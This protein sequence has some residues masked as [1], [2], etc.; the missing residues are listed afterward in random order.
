MSTQETG[1][2]HRR[3]I[4]T[5]MLAKMVVDI[6]SQIFNP[7]LS[8]LSA[9]LGI[10]V[11]QL[12][13]LVGLRNAMGVFA[14]LSGALSDRLGYKVVLRVALLLAAAGSLLLAVS[15][16]PWMVV[17]SIILGGLGTSAFVPNLQA[18]VSAR[19]PY[20]MRARGLG[21]VEYSWALT[22]IFGLSLVGLLIAAAG[23]RAPFFVLAAGM[24][25]MSFVFG[26]MPGGHKRSSEGDGVGQ[27]R[28]RW[29]VWLASIFI[30]KTNR[31]ST[32]ATIIAG[33][34]S[35]F[36]AMQITIAHGV[37]LVSR[38]ELDAAALGLVA[39]LIGCFD[40]ASSV[41]VSLFTDRIGKKR[42]VLIGIVGSLLAYCM[43][44][45]LDVAVVPAVLSFALVRMFFEFNIVSHFTLLS[46][47]APAQRGQV[48]TLGA[49]ITTLGY[50]LAGFTGPWLYVNVGLRALAWSSA[51]TIG[52]ALIVVITLVKEEPH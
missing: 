11:V 42:S 41:A 49:A 3:L 39:L 37:W 8:I 27:V 1:L 14:P 9:G 10:G 30:V 50:T 38:Y 22:G 29:F 31:R 18:F 20:S 19:L 5:G 2:S 15:T 28:V 48:M 21:I 43:M 17:L 51:A 35:F 7:F 23:W 45:F 24:F 47:Q 33:T 25:A 32:Y 40:L 52:L 36:A 13:R 4:G 26:A 12:G 6:G 44:P 46:E 16:A 34:L